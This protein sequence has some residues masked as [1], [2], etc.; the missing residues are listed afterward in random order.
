MVFL[1]LA[2]TRESPKTRKFE[3]SDH[4][5]LHMAGMKYY[6]CQSFLLQRTTCTKIPSDPENNFDGGN[7][8]QERETTFGGQPATIYSM[9]Q[10]F[11]EMKKNVK[12]S[13][14][15]IFKVSVRDQ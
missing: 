7:A 5:D 6:N 14:R 11:N 12:I 10:T 3:E 13:R 4:A 15:E 8:D 9:F 2:T 1:D